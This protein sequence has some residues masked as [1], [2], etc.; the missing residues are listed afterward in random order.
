VGPLISTLSLGRPIVLA[1]VV[2]ALFLAA[3]I[4]SRVAGR[5][6]ARLVDRAERQGSR[7][8]FGA[9][10]IMSLRQRET[11]IGL[12]T[13]SVRYLAFGLALVLSLIVLSGG[14][15]LETIV[16][17]SFLAVIVGFAVQRFLTDVVA[18]LLMFFDGWL[19]IGD[20]VA[21]DP[22]N[23]QGIVEEVSLRSVTL[24]TIKGEIIHVPNSQVLS[25]RV[26]PRGYR[27][28][29]L[30]FFVT[31]LDRGRELIG[32]IAQIVPVGATRF[33][34]RP[35]VVE[36]ETLAPDLHAITARCA[37]AVGREWLA[38]DFLPSLLKER[39]GR[40]LLVHGPIVT[41]VDERAVQSFERASAK[42]PEAAPDQAQPSG[43][44]RRLRR[45]ARA[46]VGGRP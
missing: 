35:E 26:I 17:A 12:I 40:G 39:A 31:D 32:E 30:E 46:A 5:V 1:G 24:R 37:V 2:V 3:W 9:G 4:V 27:E 8:W 13:T 19:H 36:A 33:L 23:A 25:L 42:P 29:E 41:Y 11:A 44:G 45:R 38:D 18:G 7:S 10:R 21:V 34:R 6:A 20:T 16:G 43:L 14:H 28:I 22:W 15:R